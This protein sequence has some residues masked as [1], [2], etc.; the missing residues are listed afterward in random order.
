MTYIKKLQADLTAANE[1]AENRNERIEE[2]R[3]H[4]DSAKFK[5][6]AD[7]ERADW[8]STKDVL[9]WLNYINYFNE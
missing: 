5:E 8:I 1:R 3:K 4:L 7:G 6:Q 2:F 9:E